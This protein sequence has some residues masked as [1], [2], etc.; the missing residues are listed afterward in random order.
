MTLKYFNGMLIVMAIILSLVSCSSSKKATGSVSR[1]DI[2]GT[3][4]L[5]NISYEGLP[6]DQKLKLTLLDEGSEECLKGSTWTFPNNGYGNYT[7]TQNGPGCTS[8]ERSIVW[9]HQVENGKDVLQF[10]KLTG[11]VKA[12]DVTDGYKFNILSATENNL[13]L[14]SN[15]SFQGSPISINYSFQKK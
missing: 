13:V 5:E 15:V 2:K 4:Q 7:I 1:N 9:S 11:G 12:K 10:K 8:G 14:S 3:W 6:Q